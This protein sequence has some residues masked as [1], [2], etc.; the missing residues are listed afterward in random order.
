[1]SNHSRGEALRVIRAA[2]SASCA[3]DEADLAVES[4]AV[5]EARE[6]PGRLRFPPQRIPL[7]VVT[8]GAGVVVS[9]HPER[10]A[11][12]R[13]M[14][15]GLGRDDV[16]TAA[17]IA[18]LGRRVER[19]GQRLVGP[20]LKCACSR[21]DLRPCRPPGDVEIELAEGAGVPRLY[22]H[23]GFGEALAYAV[24]DARPDVIATV[25][26]RDGE[27]MGI[28]AA[29]ADSEELWQIGVEVAAPAR[30]GGVGR[31]LVSRLMEGVLSAGKLPYYPTVVSNLRSRALAAGLGYWPAW[32]EM[33][34]TDR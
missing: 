30:G 23:R 33:Y 16:F 1:L 8:M 9:A 10:L 20:H 15:G 17:T 24:G 11:W 3:C 21:R 28:A 4:V 22:R 7:L 14:L 31:A 12:L 18:E 6:L 25:A 13:E 26:T 34:A 2:L 27:V 5:V 29:S 32:T 19:E